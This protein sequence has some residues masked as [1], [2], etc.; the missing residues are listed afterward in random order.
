MAKIVIA[1]SADCPYFAKV[2][3]L[4]DNLAKNLPSFKLHK[5]V[6]TANDWPDWSRHCCRERGWRHQR[7]PII[8]RELVNQGGKGVLIGGANEFQEFAKAYYDAESSML[9]PEMLAV[10]KDNS[11]YKSELDAEEAHLR[12]LSRPLQVLVTASASPTAYQLLPLLMDGSVFGRSTE[13]AFTLFDCDVADAEEL[14]GLVMEAFDL[15]HPLVRSIRATANFQEAAA[16][17]DILLLLDDVLLKP[18][19]PQ[20][21][22]TDGEEDKK[23]ATATEASPA[24]GDSPTKPDKSDADAAASAAEL[25]ARVDWLSAAAA[26]YRRYADWLNAAECSRRLKVLLAGRGPVN[27]GARVLLDACPRLPARNV[28]AAGRLL[29]RQ[30]KGALAGHMKVLPSSVVDLIVWGDPAGENLV[31]LSRARVHYYDGSITGPD[32]YNQPVLDT[33]W[34]KKWLNQEFPKTMRQRQDNNL[35]LGGTGPR[36]AA[37]STAQATADTVRNWWLGG[38]GNEIYSLGVVSEGWYGIPPGRVFSFPVRFQPKGA[39]SVVED[40]DLSEE[41]VQRLAQLAE[42]AQ[43][44]YLLVFP[45]PKPPT[46]EPVVEE[47][48]DIGGDL[49]IALDDGQKVPSQTPVDMAS[50]E[51]LRDRL[52]S[53]SLP[54]L[55]AEALLKLTP[56]LVEQLLRLEDVEQLRAR[57]QRLEEAPLTTVAEEVGDAQAADD[58]EAEAEEENNDEVNEEEE[59]GE[60]G[61][62]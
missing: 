37:L 27:F 19:S 52:Q 60:E 47:S 54:A 48:V 6:R 35:L 11:R 32:S 25:A 33:V 40:V 8:W 26:V 14:E 20:E 59:A 10:A 5:I 28:A 4:A 18:P 61:D 39:W 12:S 30:A 36:S 22:A 43:R 24:E 31:D 23:A 17:A 50:V 57:L 56:D 42:A 34:D 49:E 58:A 55:S 38:S 45:P 1:G 44:D 9:S 29:E 41:S 2:E 13:L 51:Q 53:L 3:L 46:P 16:A 7:S 15:A 21:S 62:D